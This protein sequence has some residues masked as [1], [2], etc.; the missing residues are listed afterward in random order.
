M[1]SESKMSSQPQICQSKRKLR[2]RTRQPGG[3]EPPVPRQHRHASAGIA[4]CRDRAPAFRGRQ[5]AGQPETVTQEPLLA[6]HLQRPAKEPW[7][8]ASTLPC[9]G[10][11]VPAHLWV[12]PDKM[13]VTSEALFSLGKQK[14][15]EIYLGG[16]SGRKSNKP[17]TN[18][19]SKPISVS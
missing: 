13:I 19:S 7:N 3:S 4:S 1:P 16:L 18:P 9:P 17:Q 6:A 11:S 14:S 5:L 2:S 10:K 12:Q 15:T 8:L